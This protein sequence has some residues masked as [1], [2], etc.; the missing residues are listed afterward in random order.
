MYGFRE[1]SLLVQQLGSVLAMENRCIVFPN[2]LQ[3]KVEPFEL[4]DSTKPGCR[5]ILAFFLVGPEKQIPSTSVIP[6]Q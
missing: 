3:H 6:P 4:A 2:L 1:R 5:K